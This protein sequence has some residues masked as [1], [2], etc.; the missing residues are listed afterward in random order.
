MLLCYIYY[1]NNAIYIYDIII[2][3]ILYNSQFRD[4]ETKNLHF[5]ELRRDLSDKIEH[6]A[7][8]FRFII[9]INIIILFIYCIYYNSGNKELM[10][11]MKRDICE[12]SFLN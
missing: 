4:F 6:D 12:L 2:F 1:I 8:E 5:I 3:H 11:L 10:L 7:V 9:N